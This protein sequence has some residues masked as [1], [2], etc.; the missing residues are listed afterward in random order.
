MR[1]HLKSMQ[2]RKKREGIKI[3]IF[4]HRRKGGKK[5]LKGSTPL[6]C[7]QGDSGNYK[8]G[9]GGRAPLSLRRRGGN[10]AYPREGKKGPALLQGRESGTGPKERKKTTAFLPIYSEASLELTSTRRS[11]QAEVKRGWRKT[12][13][14]PVLLLAGGAQKKASSLGGEGKPFL[15]R[16]EGKYRRGLPF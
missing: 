5:G 11:S 10:T 1:Q 16:G 7:V 3:Y 14:N 13:N 12:R 15:K 4:L 6:T 8:E 2:G 9:R